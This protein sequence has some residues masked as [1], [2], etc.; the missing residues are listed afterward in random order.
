MNSLLTGHKILRGSFLRFSSTYRSVSVGEPFTAAHRV[1]IGTHIKK[2]LIQYQDSNTLLLTRVCI[3]KD[4][5][6]ISP[7][8]DIPLYANDNE[9]SIVNMVVE[10]PRWTNAKVEV[11]SKLINVEGPFNTTYI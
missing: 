9:K 7:F 3:E 10:V 1:F 2:K 8:H 6:V 4:G 11:I 5:K